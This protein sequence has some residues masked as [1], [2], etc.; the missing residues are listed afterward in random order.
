MSVPVI[1]CISG[2]CLG[3]GMELALNCDI[4]VAAKNSLL[5]LPEVRL[6][7]LPGAGGTQKLSRIVG[8]GIAK[9]L[10]QTGKIFNAEEAQKYGVVN[11]AEN[12]FEAAYKRTLDLAR[13]ICDKGPVGVKMAKKALNMS[14][15]LDLDEGLKWEGECYKGVIYTEDRVEGLK[16][17]VEKRKPE[18]KGK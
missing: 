14:L 9:E 7:I 8:L 17:F 13:E 18:Y 3:G 5:G 4:R 16:A 2:P 10:I 6:G 1:G 11:Y 15:E 12:D